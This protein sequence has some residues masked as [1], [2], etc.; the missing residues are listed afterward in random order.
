[1]TGGT[2]GDMPLDDMQREILEAR[3]RELLEK[4][5]W[6]KTI[7]PSEVARA[8]SKEELDQLN[9]GTWRDAMD[10]V[11]SIVWDLRNSREVEI[12]Q[13]GEALDSNVSLDEVRGPI[14]VR[15]KQSQRGISQGN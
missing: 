1:M 8:L 5:E 11:R 15:A 6:P 10:D 7:C 3:L 4:R 2:D 9:A 13:K 12:L 14:R